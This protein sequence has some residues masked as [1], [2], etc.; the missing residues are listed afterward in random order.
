M[1]QEISYRDENNAVEITRT[2]KGVRLRVI[3]QQSGGTPN[4]IDIPEKEMEM[5]CSQVL[6]FIDS[7]REVFKGKEILKERD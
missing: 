2:E 3:D 7:R 4:D 1:L 5:L 6:L